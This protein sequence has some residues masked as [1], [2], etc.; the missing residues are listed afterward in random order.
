M[1]SGMHEILHDENWARGCAVRVTLI[2]TGVISR[3]KNLH[4]LGLMC[5]VFAEHMR[6]PHV[7]CA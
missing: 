1:A 3:Q 6:A 7:Q 5:A 2:Q 4:L